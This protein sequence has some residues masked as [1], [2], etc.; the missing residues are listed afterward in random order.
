MF[1]ILRICRSSL[2][3]VAVIFLPHPPEI[4]LRVAFVGW[5]QNCRTSPPPFNKQG[6]KRIRSQCFFHKPKVNTRLVGSLKAVGKERSACCSGSPA[7]CRRLFKE[8]KCRAP[9]QHNNK[10]Q[11]SSKAR[12]GESE[13]FVLGAG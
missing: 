8:D 12:P 4:V 5:V 13:A 1:L 7:V 10:A 11:S 2:E 6:C 3:Q 9:E